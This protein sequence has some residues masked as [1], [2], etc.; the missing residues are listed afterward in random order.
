MQLKIEEAQMPTYTID[1]KELKAQATFE[2]VLAHYRIRHTVRGHRVSALCP[3]HNDRDP[4]LRIDLGKKVWRCCACEA[5]GNILD[6]VARMERQTAP[7]AL[8]KVART[9][10]EICGLELGAGHPAEGARMP[11]DG[12]EAPETGKPAPPPSRPAGTRPGG[13]DATPTAEPG[14]INPP[15]TITLKLDSEH[16]YFEERRIDHD[17]RAVFGLGYAG[18]GMMAGRIA[19]PIHNERGQLVAYAGRW[20]GDPPA[21]QPR[22]KLPPNFRKSAALFNLHRVGGS[23]HLVVVEGFFAVFRL[24]ALGI[25]A[26][27]LM[28]HDLSAEHV[29][30]LKA[31]GTALVTVMLDGDDAGRTAVEKIVPSLARHGVFVREA[32][33]PIGTQPDTV[34]EELLAEL[35]A[36]PESLRAP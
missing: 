35:V 8:P 29:R 9:L 11:V 28:G 7:G 36:L 17:T 22:Y 12:P 14:P 3:F 32:A 19:I 33:L 13:S 34:G 1:F 24:Q 20:P 18:R 10:I 4:S 2:P 26:V 16:P 15:L 30:L 6:F 31:A 27:A 25:P 21:G 5:K 23:R